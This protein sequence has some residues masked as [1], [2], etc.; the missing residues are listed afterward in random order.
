MLRLAGGMHV[1][2]DPI[3]SCLGQYSRSNTRSII[4][5]TIDEDHLSHHHNVVFETQ[6]NNIARF[7]ITNTIFVY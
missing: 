4:T 2:T 7:V 5:I 6:I 3:P 1:L